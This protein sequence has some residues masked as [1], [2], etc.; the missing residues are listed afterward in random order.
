MHRENEE[1][2]Q[3]M[4]GV[5]RA[6]RARRKKRRS[7]GTLMRDLL[8]HPSPR[9]KARV[10][11]RM[12]G[13]VARAIGWRRALVGLGVLCLLALAGA[14][15]WQGYLRIQR[16]RTVRKARMFLGA[17]AFQDSTYWLKRALDLNPRSIEANRIAAELG[18]ISGS[19]LALTWWRRVTELQPGVPEN[20]FAWA[21]AALR[22]NQVEVAGQALGFVGKE[23]QNTP[24]YH[25]L[26]AG[27]AEALNDLGRAE[28][29]LREAIRLDPANEQYELRLAT[30][31]LRSSDSRINA[32]ARSRVEQLGQKAEHRRFAFKAL[33]QDDLTRGRGH[34]ALL[35]AR[36]L[37]SGA[38]AAFEDRIFYLDL[39]KQFHE[40]NFS[41]YLS[42][43]Q[44]DAPADPVR[45]SA[46]L[47]WFNAKGMTLVAVDWYKSLP[48]AT[49]ISSPVPATIAQSYASLH[50]W[51][52]VKKLVI[53]TNWE[54][55]EF[56]RLAFLA[57]VLR[58]EGDGRG[59]NDRW[60]AA[61][62]AAA[63][64]PDAQA[65]LARTAYGWG[66]QNEADRIL[67]T[68]A[69]RAQNQEWALKELQQMYAATQ[70]T[71]GLLRVASR[72]V[73]LHPNDAAAL[74]NFASLSCLLNV[75]LELAEASASQAYKLQSENPV[76]AAT[77][78]FALYRSG[79]IP[80]ALQ[81]INTID[82]QTLLKPPFAI[83]YGLVQAGAGGMDAARYLGIAE[84]RNLLPEEKE[85]IREARSRL[86]ARH[87]PM[88]P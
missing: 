35:R 84:S 43:L 67:W 76:V 36:T 58:E 9:E 18:E 1:G 38:D 5:I 63:D 51:S 52:S 41:S 50:D 45:V 34:D 16:E 85:L 25:D 62:K 23:G 20:Y 4:R 44:A 6:R 22:F 7:W 47:N 64:R 21:R 55:L 2:R 70:N 13:R 49:R 72:L 33:I 74:N 73:D 39:L 57:R 80:A 77:Y 12:L 24:A 68:A 60:N 27:A 32:A 3:R 26:Q 78:A 79:K 88:T 82:Q 8:T 48:E 75:N 11:R 15:G 29:E 31:H 53:G 28:A 81:V 40:A 71:K 56:S 83:Y 87:E 54:H 10:A 14:A 69:Q 61:V 65:I 30:I 19:P 17:R 37:A 66:W 59:S 42:A 86:A 46:L